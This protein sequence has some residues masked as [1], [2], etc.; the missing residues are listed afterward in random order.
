MKDP[1]QRAAVIQAYTRSLSTIWIVD[2]PMVGVGLL[3][4]K[5]IRVGSSLSLG[6]NELIAVYTVLAIRVYTLKRDVVF[7][8]KGDV[9]KGVHTPMEDEESEPKH[10]SS[11]DA[12]ISTAA[13]GAEKEKERLPDK[14]SHPLDEKK[15]TDIKGDE[16]V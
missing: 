5:L 16:K 12:G 3:I 13:K 2:T 1:D 7:E 15:D 11:P 4:G 10:E 6:P 8:K 14:D 9:E